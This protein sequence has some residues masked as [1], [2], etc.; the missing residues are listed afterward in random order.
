MKTALVTGGNKGIGLE[1]TRMLVDS[2]YQVY[3]VA[4]DFSTFELSANPHVAS[5]PYDL[6]NIDGIGDM[7]KG[8]GNIDI[9]INNAGVMYSLP[10]DDYP[11]EKMERILN[12]NIKA[13]VAL[14]RE[15]SKSMIAAGAGRIVDCFPHRPPGHLVRDHQSRPAQRHQELCQTARPPGHRYQRRGPGAGRNRHA[16]RHP[17]RS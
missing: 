14:I 6:T 5:V 10:Y 9:L 15:V 7:I 1:V 2:G 12:L 17:R 11:D 16:C 4:R 13:P 3:V 8:I